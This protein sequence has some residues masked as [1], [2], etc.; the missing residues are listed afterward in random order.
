MHNMHATE[1]IKH[2]HEKVQHP[3]VQH[4]YLWITMSFNIHLCKWANI[5]NTNNINCK[6]S[7]KIHD[8]QRFVSQIK[9]QKEWRDNGADQLLNNKF[10]ETYEKAKANSECSSVSWSK[11][12]QCLYNSLLFVL[13]EKPPFF[14][15]SLLYTERLG[16]TFVEPTRQIGGKRLSKNNIPWYDATWGTTPT[17]QT[18]NKQKQHLFSV[19]F[20]FPSIRNVMGMRDNLF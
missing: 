7:K 13:K 14:I 3:Y 16:K 1:L 17:T 2:L 8:I 18:Q 6:V 15:Y 10:L 11:T 9:T 19:S 12:I 4:T 20:S 5:T